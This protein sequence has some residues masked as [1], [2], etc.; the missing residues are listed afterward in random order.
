MASEHAPVNMKVDARNFALEIN[1]ASPEQVDL[2]FF[3][4][5]PSSTVEILI[6]ETVARNFL[7][8]GSRCRYLLREMLATKL[9]AKP[10]NLILTEGATQALL[11][12]LVSTIS[13]RRRVLCPRP[14]FPAYKFIAGAASLNVEYYDVNLLSDLIRVE[15]L[16]ARDVVILNYPHNP[17]GLVIAD[18]DLFEVIERIATVGAEVIV[19]RSHV[20]DLSCEAA[21]IKGVQQFGSASVRFIYSI[22][23]YLCF[24]ALRIGVI[25]C[26]NQQDI[27]DLNALRSHFCPSTSNLEQEVAVALFEDIELNQWVS[28]TRELLKRR[29]YEFSSYVI[30]SKSLADEGSTFP[31]FYCN[32]A[33]IP[34]A[35]RLIGVSGTLFHG[36]SE[37][38]R[39]C[40]GVNV[41]T[42]N[43]LVRALPNTV[44]VFTVEA[45]G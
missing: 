26:I 21:L 36:Q 18:A 37:F 34:C 10:R 32:I 20:S 7:Q 9:G 30:G 4:Y 5:R 23:K 29:I 19:D 16:E 17:T 31:Y 45:E 39:Y 35:S 2:R 11:L 12:C 28:K 15:R 38:A 3:S 6:R 44:D 8:Y 42:W 25:A 13:S 40:L 1:A 24:P 41:G 22:G 33:R 43:R 27:D 14:G